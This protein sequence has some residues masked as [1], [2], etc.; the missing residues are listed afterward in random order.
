[1]RTPEANGGAEQQHR[2]CV[3]GS[4][5]NG[6]ARLENRATVAYTVTIE[7]RNLD[8]LCC[9]MEMKTCIPYVCG[10]AVYSSSV[11]NSQNQLKRSST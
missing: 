11:Y 3:A 6:I 1:M 9:P 5:E 7:P 4:Q 2:P 8:P 10:G